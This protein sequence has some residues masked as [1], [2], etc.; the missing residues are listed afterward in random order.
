MALL[1]LVERSSL[2]RQINMDTVRKHAVLGE[3]YKSLVL[4]ATKRERNREQLINKKTCK[5]ESKLPS[6]KRICQNLQLQYPLQVFLIAQLKCV[7]WEMLVMYSQQSH[8]DQLSQ[9]VPTSNSFT[10]GE[11]K[12]RT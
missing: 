4:K 11:E 10:N 7:H 1:P 8:C 3:R 12:G 6:S 5:S 9:N 2:Y